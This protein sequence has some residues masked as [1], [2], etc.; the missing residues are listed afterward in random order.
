MANPATQGLHDLSECGPEIRVQEGHLTISET[1]ASTI[2]KA[3]RQLVEVSW[4][5]YRR[6]QEILD[7]TVGNQLPLDKMWEALNSI[8]KEVD[9]LRELFERGT[10]ARDV[11]GGVV[12]LVRSDSVILL[13]GAFEH[14]K[15]DKSKTDYL[16]CLRE[17]VTAQIG[18]L[19]WMDYFSLSRDNCFRLR[20]K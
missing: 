6:M 12:D 14:A 1:E 19:G 5:G 18:Q 17:S 2:F 16:A 11:I 20:T 4:T 15:S 9:S 10:P 8:R 7:A 3:V 13:L